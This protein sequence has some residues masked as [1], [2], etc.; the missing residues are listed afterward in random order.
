M[1]SQWKRRKIDAERQKRAPGQQ[2][3]GEG[4]TTRAVTCPYCYEISRHEV[5]VRVRHDDRQKAS[6][7]WCGKPYVLHIRGQTNRRGAGSVQALPLPKGQRGESAAPPAEVTAAN[8]VSTLMRLS[9][10]RENRVYLNP[11]A[12]AAAVRR[13][14]EASARDLGLPVPDAL[15]ALLLMSNG[16]DIN[17]VSFLDAQRLVPENLTTPRPG[18]L[19]IG[20]SLGNPEHPTEFVFDPRTNQFHEVPAG[21]PDARLTSFDTFEELLVAVLSEAGRIG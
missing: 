20:C 14:R 15:A 12:G 19:V 7:S 10:D 5:Q 21:N 1:S 6:C 3:P 18:V 8:I 17:Y 2:P 13:L 4:W 9:A 11:P 16:L